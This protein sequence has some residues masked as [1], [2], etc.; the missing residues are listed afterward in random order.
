M[1]WFIEPLQSRERHHINHTFCI[2][3]FCA[4][5][6]PSGW[7]SGVHCPVKVVLLVKPNKNT[8]RN[9]LLFLLRLFLSRNLHQHK[10]THQANRLACG[11]MS[12]AVNPFTVCSTLMESGVRGSKNRTSPL[13]LVGNIK[14]SKGMRLL[15]FLRESQ[16]SEQTE[17][18]HTWHW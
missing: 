7:M 5:M 11:W 1:N 3:F 17:T 13:T 10:Q 4:D 15:S 2:D 16:E 9:V 18:E 14:V 6:W 8:K 12:R